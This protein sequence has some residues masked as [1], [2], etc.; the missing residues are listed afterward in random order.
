MDLKLSIEVVVVITNNNA[1]QSGIES[2]RIESNIGWVGVTQTVTNSPCLNN[3]ALLL[4]VGGLLR[5]RGSRFTRGW[6]DPRG[7]TTSTP[8]SHHGVPYVSFSLELPHLSFGSTLNIEAIN[9][10]SSF[11]Q[12]LR[13]IKSSNLMVMI[14]R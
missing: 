7:R 3:I 5:V 2:N 11:V 12:S 10:A 14:D 4:V 13:S 6:M 8:P 1:I 9:R